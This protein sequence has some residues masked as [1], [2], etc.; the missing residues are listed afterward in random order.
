MKLYMKPLIKD[1]PSRSTV[2]RGLALVL[3]VVLLSL[4]AAC[5][6]KPAPKEEDIVSTDDASTVD[7][8]ELAHTIPL[9]HQVPPIPSDFAVDLSEPEFQ[10]SFGLPP[11]AEGLAD[12][13]SQAGF[14][15]GVPMPNP[16]PMDITVL[17]RLPEAPAMV[18]PM[19]EPYLPMLPDPLPPVAAP[20]SPAPVVP[21]ARPTVPAPVPSAP[22]VKPV[23][24]PGPATGVEPEPSPA[25]VG[26]QPGPGIMPVLP[27][28]PASSARSLE[29]A[30]LALP[31][32]RVEVARGQRFELRLRGSGWTFLG[33]EEGKDGV[34]YETRRFED[35]HAVFVMN[36]SQPGEYLLR[37]QRQD[38][39]ELRTE[40][41]LV[42]LLVTPSIAAGAP[43]TGPTRTPSFVVAT[44]G[45]PAPEQALVPARSPEFPSAGTAAAVGSVLDGS[46]TDQRPALTQT[47]TAPLSLPGAPQ[48]SQ[49]APQAAMPSVSQTTAQPAAQATDQDATQA[50]AQ[51]AGQTPV[52]SG[53]DASV[54]LPSQSQAQTPVQPSVLTV[55]DP[56]ALI[57]LARDELSVR[58][59]NAAMEALDRYRSLYP[60]LSDEVYFLYA[61]AY[62]QD[63]PFRDIKKAYE[64]YRRV[65]DEFPRSQ[66]WRQSA[67]RTAYLERHYPGLR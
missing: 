36:P 56:A 10:E 47:G 46:S 18:L 67:D 42:R 5:V 66:F 7:S 21:Q 41:S 33:D 24:E 26:T 45:S 27:V 15:P 6:S 29:A 34:R 60:N 53:A 58:R 13:S 22:P 20:V 23:P 19:P 52:Q 8:L 38:P 28:P 16:Y 62:E 2:S 14:Q 55:S 59:V 17:S 3:V 4:L 37:F 35:N 50:S 43:A 9:F 44:L 63:T 64:N 12:A 39:L 40:A 11:L 65:R 61:L 49:A 31:E 48:V 30:P 54:Q 25:S 57:K 1:S 32:T 51:A